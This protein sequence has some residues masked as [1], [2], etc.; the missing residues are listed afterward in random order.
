MKTISDGMNL[1]LFDVLIEEF[2][3]ALFGLLVDSITESWVDIKDSSVDWKDF[4]VDVLFVSVVDFVVVFSGPATFKVKTGDL[5][6]RQSL[7][8]PFFD[9]FW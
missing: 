8:W 3:D 5:K 7:L 6:M 1:L 9:H 4:G 2:F